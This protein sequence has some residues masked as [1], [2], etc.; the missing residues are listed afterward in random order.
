FDKDWY[1]AVG[2]PILINLV[3]NSFT[4]HVIKMAQKLKG[5]VNIWRK[6]KKVKTQRELNKLY[7]KSVQ[8][9]DLG[10]RFAMVLTTAFI[11]NTFSSAL[12]LMPFVASFTYFLLYR[13]DKRD[14][15]TYHVSLE[16]QQYGSKMAE[17]AADILPMS[18]VLHCFF[19]ILLWSDPWLAPASIEP[20]SPDATFVSRFVQRNTVV[21]TIL[22]LVF[23]LVVTGINSSRFYN[24]VAPDCIRVNDNDELGFE[25]DD[26]TWSVFL[27]TIATEDDV[28]SYDLCENPAYQH[29]MVLDDAA[30]ADTSVG[31][32][33]L[34]LRRKTSRLLTRKLSSVEGLGDLE[35]G[36]WGGQEEEDLEGGRVSPASS[37]ERPP[38]PI[39][40]RTSSVHS[41]RS[42][43]S[44]HVDEDG[45]VFHAT[46]GGEGEGGGE[47]EEDEEHMMT[48]HGSYSSHPGVG[49]EEGVGEGVGAEEGEEQEDQVASALLSTSVQS[50]LSNNTATTAGTPNRTSALNDDHHAIATMFFGDAALLEQQHAKKPKK[51]GGA[52]GGGGGRG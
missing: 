20:A 31:S 11:A 14:I 10:S 27:D 38:L 40:I 29:L 49:A 25:E 19:A 43:P 44:V 26:P 4:C 46:G 1:G 48:P 2:V 3:T 21:Q 32:D 41:V 5:R 16:T 35:G 6:S 36:E 50:D 17:V 12:P 45:D 7:A 34:A 28:V 15:L 37:D 52:R 47:M 8:R 33:A 9:F 24:A 51:R 30:D 39:P 18:A 22:L 13:L 23:T 42:V